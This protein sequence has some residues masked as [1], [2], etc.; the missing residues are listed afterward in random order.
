MYLNPQRFCWPHTS[1]LLTSYQPVLW[2]NVYYKLTSAYSNI[3]YISW[4]FISFLWGSKTHNVFDPI[5]SLQVVKNQSDQF[6]IQTG[7]ILTYEKYYEL[8]LLDATYN[9]NRFKHDIKFGSK[10][11]SMSMSLN[12]S[13]KR[14]III[15]LT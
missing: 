6:K 15:H 9:D 12:R 5:S 7:T 2:I 11:G 14:K 3:K 13:P 8:L 4:K 10:I 1:Y